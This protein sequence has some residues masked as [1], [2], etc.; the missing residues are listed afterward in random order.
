MTVADEHA[1]LQRLVLIVKMTT[2][3]EEYNTEEQNSV[4]RFCGL[5]N[6]ANFSLRTK[7][8][9]RRRGSG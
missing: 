3:L 8:L 5:R 2:V 7:R 6:V 4:V 1:H 9:K